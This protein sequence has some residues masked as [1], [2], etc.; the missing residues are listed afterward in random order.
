[1]ASVV[2]PQLVITDVDVNRLA[3][4]FYE[5]S[6]IN[7]LHTDKPLLVAGLRAVFEEL[8]IDVSEAAR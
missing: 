8:G 3:Q 7:V 1:M 4:T 5:A 6:G 2:R